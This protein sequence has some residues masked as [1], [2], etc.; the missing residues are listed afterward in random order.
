MNLQQAVQPRSSANGFSRRRVEKDMGSRI[1]SKLQPGK[2]NPSRVTSLGVASGSKSVGYESPSRDRLVYLTTGL[3][4]HQ[5]DVQ[6][7]NGSVFSGI[8]HATNA[9]KDFGIVLKMARLTK[10]AS[11]RG[12]K[13]ASD[14]IGKAPSKTLIIPAHEFVQIIAEA[15]P[16]TMH[17][18]S[19]ESQC[20]KQQEIMLDS[21]ISQSRHVEVERELG[22]WCPDE[23][24]PQCSDLDN[25][26]E[27]PWTGGWDQF[28]VNERLF[29]V[30]STFNEELYTTKLEKGPQMRE[31][32]EEAIRI[33]REIEGEETHDLHLA[34][35]R[36][37]YPHGNFDI[38]EETRFSS[39]FRGVDDSGYEDEDVIVD[40]HNTETFGNASGPTISRS[41][42]DVT[43][44][45]SHD[46][47][48]DEVQ[49]SEFNA[50]REFY[51]SSFI[52]SEH[53]SI[54]AHAVED[55]ISVQENH[56]SEGAVENAFC[57]EFA[58]V[59]MLGEEAQTTTIEDLQS[60][61]PT[62]KEVS[63][64]AGTSDVSVKSQEKT[65]FGE[66]SDDAATGQVHSITQSKTST[67]PSGSSALSPSDDGSATL[68]LS[69]PALSPSSSVGSMS[70]EKSTL[71]PNAK[72]FKLNPN[73]KSFIPSQTPVRPLSPVADGSFY[74]LT[75]VPA[76]PPMHGMPVGIGIGPSYA[77]PQPM[78]FNP[79]AAPIQSPPAYFPANGP[80]YG[81]QMIIGHPRQIMY[82]PG[83]PTYKGR[84]F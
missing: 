24:D 83:Y 63:D 5:V 67:G 2:S 30:K 82:M 44:G 12:Q 81:Q 79:S 1:E 28:K 73:A 29:G 16:V 34:E 65:S 66:L 47:G 23:D 13:V 32:E 69:G 3:I 11:S 40:S 49:S 41:S 56:I 38:D 62:K 37:M 14:T 48:Q 20:E 78:I 74:Y 6:V 10:D 25:I 70:S 50:N 58:T 22:R 55:D 52:A 33:A 21:Y 54:G 39:V 7:K 61:P 36:G 76:V 51:Q 35:E 45:K 17:G 75:N 18:L 42:A 31:L 59:K 8:F 71:N 15:L 4:G 26:F 57:K 43:S 80:Q 77:G 72:E 19:S 53:S 84:E 64:K 9:D 27:T 46:V 68:P 60:S